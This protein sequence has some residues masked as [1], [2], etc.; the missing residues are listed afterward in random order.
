[1][2]P[3]R[4]RRPGQGGGGG[5]SRGLDSQSESTPNVVALRWAAV[6]RAE[7]AA[8]GAVR[9]F[10]L[11]AEDALAAVLD[12]DL[13]SIFRLHQLVNRAVCVVL[14]HHLASEENWRPSA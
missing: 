14:D 9:E 2:S 5:K 1:M 12:G 10:M 8:R 11:E 3:E 6:D 13:D 4:P 7:V